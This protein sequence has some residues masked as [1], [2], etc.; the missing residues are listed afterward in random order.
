[1]ITNREAFDS[2]RL[3][4]EVAAALEKLYP[5]KLDFEKCRYLIG[6]HRNH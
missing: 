1:M 6:N 3:G 2:T 4:I 5:G